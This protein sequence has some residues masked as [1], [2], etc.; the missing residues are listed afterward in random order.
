MWPPWV[1]ER[2]KQAGRPHRAAPTETMK[3]L[4][5][6][7]P[8]GGR[9]MAAPVAWAAAGAL[10]RQML[11]RE[12]AVPVQSGL[13]GPA[14]YPSRRRPAFS[15]RIS[16]TGWGVSTALPI[17]CVE[18]PRAGSAYPPRKTPRFQ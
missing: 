12:G 5:R 7:R 15:E 6:D 3:D 8:L 13:A 1:G 16:M 11:K 9:R 4:S 17:R 14:A 18:N 10:G 2:T